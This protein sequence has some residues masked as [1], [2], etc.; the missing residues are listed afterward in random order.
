MNEETLARLSEA[1][2]KAVRVYGPRFGGVIEHETSNMLV[3]ESSA[4]LAARILRS[5]DEFLSPEILVVPRQEVERL[6]VINGG[7]FADDAEAV[8]VKCLVDHGEFVSRA[9][10]ENDDR[11]VQI[12]AAGI[13]TQEEQVFLFRRKER[14]PKYALYGKETVWQGA[15]V[16]KSV[17]MQGIPLLKHALLERIKRNL[18]LSRGFETKLVGF[19]WDVSDARE[20]RHLG[21]TFRVDI[22]NP[23]AANDLKKKEFRRGRGHGL[24]G[25]FVNWSQ[26]AEAEESAKLEPWSL[27]ILGHFNAQHPLSRDV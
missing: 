17:D 22:D 14:D 18:F 21:V 27:A 15:H 5:L 11:Y 9:D 26:L 24:A 3:R 12:I 20:S 6:P 19:C 25:G 2:Q 4:K 1:V 7:Y 8:V 23:E 13:L 16:P 10:V